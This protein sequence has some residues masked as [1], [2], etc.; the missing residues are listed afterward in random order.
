MFFQVQGSV[1]TVEY[2]VYG[3]EEERILDEL[4]EVEVEG[5]K[6]HLNIF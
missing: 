3:N 4:E 1:F 5:S 6:L 2:E